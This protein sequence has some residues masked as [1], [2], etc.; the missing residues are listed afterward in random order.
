MLLIVD[1]VPFPSSSARSTEREAESEA[2]QTVAINTQTAPAAA[3]L[4]RMHG[5]WLPCFL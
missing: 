4:R 3:D 5:G 2:M 1:W